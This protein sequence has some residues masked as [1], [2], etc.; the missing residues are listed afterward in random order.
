MALELRIAGRTPGCTEF[1]RMPLRANC[2]AAD[3]VMS[4]TAPFD[5]L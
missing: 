5:A 1:T 3:F 4:R 2:T